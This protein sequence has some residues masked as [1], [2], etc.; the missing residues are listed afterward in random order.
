ML[1]PAS[2][3]EYIKGFPVETQK[4]LAQIRNAVKKLSPTA[5]EVISYGMPAFKLNGM[6]VFY[7]GYEKHIGFYPTPSGI[8]AFKKELS[9]YKN[10]KGSV[11]FPLDK[12]LPMTLINNIIKFRIAKNL[13]TAKT[14]KK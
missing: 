13:E 11:Q 9:V 5:E 2:V 8:A 12:P 14:K 3:D 10:A 6:L 4:K 7:A 1:K